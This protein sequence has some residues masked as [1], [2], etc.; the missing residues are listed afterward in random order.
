MAELVFWNILFTE[1]VN[2]TLSNYLLIIP[3]FYHDFFESYC[4]KK[5]NKQ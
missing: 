3:S 4:R 1:F 5:V 2:S